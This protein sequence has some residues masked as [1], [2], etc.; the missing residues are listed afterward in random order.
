MTKELVPCVTAQYDTSLATYCVYCC[1]AKSLLKQSSLYDGDKELTKKVISQAKKRQDKSS[2]SRTTVNEQAGKTA[3][4][5][6]AEEKRAMDLRAARSEKRVSD[7]AYRLLIAYYGGVEK[8]A[9]NAVLFMSSDRIKELVKQQLDNQNKQLGNS[10]LDLNSTTV[11]ENGSVRPVAAMPDFVEDMEN[12]RAS[13]SSFQTAKRLKGLSTDDMRYLIN[14]FGGDETKTR[15]A[16]ISESKYSLDSKIGKQREK[17]ALEQKNE[18]RAQ[19]IKEQDALYDMGGNLSDEDQQMVDDIRD[20]WQ[21]NN[22]PI[23]NISKNYG[24]RRPDLNWFYENFDTYGFEDIKSANLASANDKINQALD[25]YNKQVLLPTDERYRPQKR[26]SDDE[27]KYLEDARDW[28]K[29]NGGSSNSIRPQY[30]PSSFPIYYNEETELREKYLELL[31]IFE[32]D[33]LNGNPTTGIYYQS[34]ALEVGIPVGGSPASIGPEVATTYVANFNEGWIA[35]YDSIGLSGSIGA[36]PISYQD[37]DGMIYG[38]C[39]SPKDYINGF[40]Q[41]S[42]GDMRGKSYAS[43]TDKDSDLVQTGDL[44]QTNVG[45]SVGYSFYT[46]NDLEYYDD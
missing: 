3:S 31:T 18:E 14:Y 13:Y 42:F 12:S 6:N 20:S 10:F 32:D 8:L 38:D 23:E 21:N 4:Q 39:D 45:T 16:V 46:L 28:I 24:N 17:K 1:R 30:L 9:E 29:E 43:S 25:E 19:S 22:L 33:I 5:I 27:V 2:S 41:N 7:E 11:N 36:S 34:K 26:L 35:E 44:F 15:N 40:K 37:S